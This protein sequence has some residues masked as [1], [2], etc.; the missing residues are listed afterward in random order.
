MRQ[1]TEGELDQMTAAEKELDSKRG[2]MLLDNSPAAKANAL[3]LT[4]YFNNNNV[5]LKCA[6]DS[7]SRVHVER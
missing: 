6:I 3:V 7:C 4:E 1:Y 2:L 5:A